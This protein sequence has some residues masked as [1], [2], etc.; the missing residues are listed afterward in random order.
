MTEQLP[1]ETS[2]D[3]FSLSPAAAADEA[4]RLA[5]ASSIG[6]APATSGEDGASPPLGG[7]AGMAG[8]V[9]SRL[10]ARMGGQHAAWAFAEAGAAQEASSLAGEFCHRYCPI[11]H[12]CAGERCAVFRFE[13]D[14][15]A[16]L[17]A[18]GG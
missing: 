1:V 11:E 14:A 18:A 8:E 9:P 10:A 4:A 2:Y 17:E 5:T 15:V 3:V 16:F 6:S 13:R 12:R 7:P